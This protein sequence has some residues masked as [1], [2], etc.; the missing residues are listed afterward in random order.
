MSLANL[1]SLKS[2]GIKDNK[3][4]DNGNI[5]ARKPGPKPGSHHATIKL[6]KDGTPKQKP[7]PK[8]GSK[9]KTNLGN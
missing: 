1:Y 5:I 6:K 9:H 8:P 2:A 3:Y 4:D 7:G